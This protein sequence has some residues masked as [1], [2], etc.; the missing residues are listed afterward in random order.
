M[1]YLG[2]PNSENRWRN[3]YPKMV[4]VK[5]IFYIS[6]IPAAHAKYSAANVMPSVGVVAV[7]KRLPCHISQFAPTF[8]RGVKN[9]QPRLVKIWDFVIS[10]KLLELES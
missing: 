1:G 8:R 9:Q 10:R 6:P 5:K 3:G 4:K 7:V 2:A